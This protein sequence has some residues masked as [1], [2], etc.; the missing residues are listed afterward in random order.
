MVSK[1]KIYGECLVKALKKR[2]NAKWF[3]ARDRMH[4]WNRKCGY[5]SISNIYKFLF[6]HPNGPAPKTY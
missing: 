6:L 3:G 4:I 5:R 2:I 1:G